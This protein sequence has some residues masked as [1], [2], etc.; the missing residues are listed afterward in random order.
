MRA[1]IR[2]FTRLLNFK[3]RRRGDERLREE[4]ESHRQR[5]TT[6]SGMAGIYGYSHAGP[7]WRNALMKVYGDEV[8]GNYFD[9]LGVQP[10]VWLGLLGLA[11]LTPLPD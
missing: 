2:L 5:N 3:T 7:S 6:F 11:P 9:L 8:T 10:E 1:L 4:I